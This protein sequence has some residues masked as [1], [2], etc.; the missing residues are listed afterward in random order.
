MKVRGPFRRCTI[1]MVTLGLLA[2]GATPTAA[3]APSVGNKKWTPA[4]L[5]GGNS[6]FRWAA[7]VPPWMRP[8]VELTLETHWSHTTTNNQGG[9]EFT[10]NSQG[11]G[12]VRYFGNSRCLCGIGMARLRRHEHGTGLVHVA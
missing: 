2:L 4:M 3:H 5:T 11:Q 12:L 9:I 8:S 1:A 6:T 7:A 10:Y